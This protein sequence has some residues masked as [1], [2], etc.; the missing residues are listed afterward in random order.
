MI[1]YFNGP[2]DEDD[3]SKLGEFWH[4]CSSEGLLFSVIIML[5]ATIS[6]YCLTSTCI[7][8]SSSTVIGGLYYYA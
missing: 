2:D 3:G 4:L 6:G 8:K 7:E 5:R 1:Y